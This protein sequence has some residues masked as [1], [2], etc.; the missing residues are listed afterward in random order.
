M[1]VL[2]CGLLLLGPLVPLFIYYALLLP[3]R[4]P[5]NIPAVPFW[6]ALIPFFKDVD[7][8]DIFRDYIEK[9][10][11]KHGAVKL[12]FGAQ[13][14]ILVHKPA[15]LAEIFKEEDFYQKSGNQKKIPHS[16]LAAFLGDNIISSHG[17]AWRNYQSVVKPGLQRNFEVTN[18]ARNAARLC[19]LLEQAQ[20]GSGDGGIPVQ[21]LLQRYSAANCSE[22]L[23]QARL[24]VS[25]PQTS[26]T[27]LR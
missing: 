20:L 19:E 5:T 15:Y 11:R 9:P 13:W 16:I 25:K 2:V 14:N 24:G 21:E 18:I 26:P 10:L 23:L 3:P 8:A 6:V 1:F 27:Q 12:F 7:Q 22:V 17:E 4:Y